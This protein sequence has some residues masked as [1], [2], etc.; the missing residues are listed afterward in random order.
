MND[1]RNR[2]ISQSHQVVRV[3]ITAKQ[4]RLKEDHRD[5]P[6]RGGSSEPWQDHLG[7]QRLDGEQ[8]QRTDKNCGCVDNKNEFVAGGTRASVCRRSHDRSN[9]H[10]G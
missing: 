8:E 1:Y 7:K 4:Q 9:D 2:P 10:F 3:S 6:D 5:R